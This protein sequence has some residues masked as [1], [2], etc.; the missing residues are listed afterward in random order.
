MNLQVNTYIPVRIILLIL[1]TAAFAMLGGCKELTT[2]VDEVLGK[3]GSRLTAVAMA[4]PAPQSQDKQLSPPPDQKKTRPGSVRKPAS[5]DAKAKPTATRPAKAEAAASKR[6]AEPK[7]PPLGMAGKKRAPGTLSPTTRA[8]K[9]ERELKGFFTVERDPFRQ[10]TEVLPSDC[11]P[12][13]PLCRFDRSQL[14]LVGVIQIGSGQFKGMVEDPDG[15]G[16]FVSAGM[17]IGNATVTQV[18]NKGVTLRV[19]KTREDVLI[20]LYKKPKETEEF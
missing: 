8:P 2:A 9:K 1:A 13:V 6:P 7:T 3:T 20:P 16:Y 4:A 14:K 17:Q 11:P 18:S 10:P 19:H 5:E 12:S 15:R